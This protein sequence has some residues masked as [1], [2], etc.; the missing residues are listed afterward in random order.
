MN[1]GQVRLFVQV[2]I[3]PIVFLD[4]FSQENGK[5]RLDSYA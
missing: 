4:G 3:E 2:D 5:R 1:T